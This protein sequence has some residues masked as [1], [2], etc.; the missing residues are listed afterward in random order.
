[1][2]NLYYILDTV[3]KYCT[4]IIIGICVWAP[5]QCEKLLFS[6]EVGRKVSLPLCRYDKTITVG[7]HTINL[8]QNR[9]V[10]E[11]KIAKLYKCKH[12]IFKIPHLHTLSVRWCGRRTTRTCQKL[13][14]FVHI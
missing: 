10:F 13:F 2:Y 14:Y 1:M 9:T 4:A 5:A 12:R 11:I 3:I 7:M 8:R 6:R